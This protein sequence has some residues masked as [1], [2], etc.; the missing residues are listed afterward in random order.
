VIAHKIYIFG[1]RQ[2]TAMN[3]LPLNDLYYFDTHNEK[4]NFVEA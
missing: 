3:E 2:G 1:G 4:W